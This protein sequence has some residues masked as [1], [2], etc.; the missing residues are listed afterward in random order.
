MRIWER[1]LKELEE[2]KRNGTFDPHTDFG[3]FTR[4]EYKS[5]CMI[6]NL[7]P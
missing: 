4:G 5:G 6:R 1:E 7:T 2:K 3:S